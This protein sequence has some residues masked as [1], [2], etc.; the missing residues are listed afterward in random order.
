MNSQSVVFKTRGEKV[1]PILRTA[2]GAH[3]VTSIATQ[4]QKDDGDD[5]GDG[6]GCE[7]GDGDR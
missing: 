3:W 7:K 2:L 5:D 6:K 4:K 1:M